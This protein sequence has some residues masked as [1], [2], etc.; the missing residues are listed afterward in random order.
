M[1]E[2]TT[3]YAVERLAQTSS[4]RGR[5]E[6]IV[7]ELPRARSYMHLDTVMTMID[8]DTF[9]MY[10]GVMEDAR[11]WSCDRATLPTSLAVVPG[12][13][14]STPF[15][16]ALGLEKFR[17]FT[18]GG[19]APEADREQWDDGNNVLAVEPGVVVGIR[20]QCRHE[21]ETPS[22]RHRSDHVPAPSCHVAGVAL[23]A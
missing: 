20:P 2:R 10:P 9:L 16:E 15:A 4:T 13:S 6:V 23:V 14:C 21:H 1:G 22:R 7:V 5:H 11:I 8:R 19:D 3:P 18:T 17:V 12:R